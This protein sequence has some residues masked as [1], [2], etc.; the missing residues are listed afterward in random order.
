MLDTRE[1]ERER[2]FFLYT[3]T[4]SYPRF[5]FI[6]IEDKISPALCLSLSLL[7]YQNAILFHGNNP[8]V[9]S[10]SLSLQKKKIRKENDDLSYP[11][12]YPLSYIIL[13]CIYFFSPIHTIMYIYIY[14]HLM[15][16]LS[17]Y[18]YWI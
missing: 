2:E 16:V 15:H 10:L 6:D 18:I 8:R 14:V 5:D 7:I 3:T 17:L 12:F 4:L 1:R 13:L 9:K 11:L